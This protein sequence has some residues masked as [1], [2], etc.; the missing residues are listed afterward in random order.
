MAS[1]SLIILPSVADE[2]SYEEEDQTMMKMDKAI[3]FKHDKTFQLIDGFGLDQDFPPCLCIG[4][5]HGLLALLD[6]NSNPFLFNPFSRTRIPLPAKQSL[7]SVFK[8]V[9]CGNPSDHHKKYV[10]I[11]ICSSGP[12][13]TKLAFCRPGDQHWTHLQTGIR[14]HYDVV[15]CDD[16]MTAFALGPG[17][18]VESW[19]LNELHCPKKRTVIDRDDSSCNSIGAADRSFPS[20]LYSSRWYLA[21]GQGKSMFLVVRYIGEFVRPCDGKVVYEGDTLTDYDPAPL[22]CPYKTVAFRVFKF[23]GARREWIGVERLGEF[24]MFLGGNQSMMVSKSSS[25]SS[26]SK[27]WNM[28]NNN[29]IYFTDD[30][31][32]RMN[33]DYSYGGHDNG[34]F[35]LE[36]GSIHSLVMGDHYFDKIVPPPFFLDMIH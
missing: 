4:S 19:D 29:V 15:C 11:V 35:K 21:L 34:V 30:Y 9:L 24:A 7:D 20:D 8:L 6:Q 13:R 33:E 23:D 27:E 16:T 17:P 12:D 18:E 32:D 36:D 2:F 10:V 1:P 14:T 25:S 5:S 28:G 26:S 31:W 3:V 22:V